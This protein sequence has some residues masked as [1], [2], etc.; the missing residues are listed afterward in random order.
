MEE[1]ISIEFS[2][3]LAGLDGD[4]DL[5]K[6]LL[7]CWFEEKQFDK[8]VLEKLIAKDGKISAASYVHRMKG[9][10]GALGAQALFKAAQE[11]ENILKE[12]TQGDIAK[13]CEQTD[14]LYRKTNAA[15]NA[16]RTNL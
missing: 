1:N 11:L 15:H 2:Q 12:K 13:A 16:I 4:K 7:D 5:Y 3:A 6:T 9:A 8:T 10:A 14:M